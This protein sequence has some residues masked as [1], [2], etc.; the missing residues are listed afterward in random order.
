MKLPETGLRGATEFLGDDPDFHQQYDRLQATFEQ[1]QAER[2]L[3]GL[4]DQARLAAPFSA[5]RAEKYRQLFH[6]AGIDPTQ[7]PS[8]YPWVYRDRALVALEE[9]FALTK[10]IN[11]RRG[12]GDLIRSIDP[13]PQTIRTMWRAT[14]LNESPDALRRLASSNDAMSLPSPLLVT[15]ADRLQLAG[16]HQ[17]AIQLLSSAQAE[18]PNDFW[19]HYALGALFL[20]DGTAPKRAIGQLTAAA[21]LRPDSVEVLFALAM[22]YEQNKDLPAAVREYQVAAQRDAKHPG[23]LW[24][25]ALALRKQQELAKAAEVLEHAAAID[26]KDTAVWLALAEVQR[27]VGNVTGSAKAYEQAIA[28]MPHDPE[29]PLT[30]CRLLRRVGDASHSLAVALSALERFP[31]NSELLFEHG[32]ASVEMRDTDNA[33]TDAH[34]MLNHE[35]GS[36][37]GQVLLGLI[38]LAKH[39]SDEAEGLFHAALEIDASNAEALYQLGERARARKDFASAVNYYRLAVRKEPDLAL[40]QFALGESLLRLG[41]GDAAVPYLRRAMVLLNTSAWH[42][43][44]EPLLRQAEATQP[45][46]NKR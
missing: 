46:V 42:E 37:L 38:A 21:A 8:S 16:A 3:L 25:Y 10:D 13:T 19:L 11:E 26:P 45:A 15:L 20:A 4:I 43:K 33:E 14:L 9:W 40:M 34:A 27:G 30:L 12:V 18:H 44:V 35:P 22:A 39:N 23:V 29:L 7:P 6:D 41:Q 36:P 31:G 5:V 2:S 17:E 28:L 24:H 1:I 32:A